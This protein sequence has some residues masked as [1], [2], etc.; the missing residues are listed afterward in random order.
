MVSASFRMRQARDPSLP[1]R[2]ASLA[3]SDL[4]DTA[5]AE[6]TRL[7][8]KA[9]RDRVRRTPRGRP[10]SPRSGRTGSLKDE[11]LGEVRAVPAPFSPSVNPLSHGRLPP[12]SAAA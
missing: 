11:V 7:D 6:R 3:P 12:G 8:R 2:H 10:P 4:G 9:Q 1:R 5:L